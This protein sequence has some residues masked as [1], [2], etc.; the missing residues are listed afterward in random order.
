[1]VAGMVLFKGT[2]ADQAEEVASGLHQ[3]AGRERH[4]D[5]LRADLRL[6]ARPDHPDRSRVTTCT[7]HPDGHR[8]PR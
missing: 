2:A 5:R 8:L 1:M 7:R 6:R 4:R 3:G